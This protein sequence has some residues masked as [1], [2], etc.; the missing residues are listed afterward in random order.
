MHRL[1]G[2]IGGTSSRWAFVPPPGGLPTLHKLP[3]Y[4]PA[5]GQPALLQQALRD[6]KLGMGLGSLHATV[7]G[8]GCGTK[9]RADR[10]RATLAEVWPDASVEVESDLLG[11]ARALY[12]HDAGLVLILGTGMNAGYYNGM[13]LHLPMPSLG[14][15]LGDEGSGAD[16]GKHLLRDA[17]YGALPDALF[18]ALFPEGADLPAI[19]EAVHRSPVPQAFLASFAAP[20]A[21]VTGDVHA[22]DLVASRFDALAR[23]LARFFAPDERKSVRACG[24]VAFGFRETLKESLAQRGMR[25]TAAEADPMQGLLRYHAALK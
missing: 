19:L 14:Y 11:A 2:D 7:Y 13:D 4:N 24:S 15:V 10:M 17:L 25:L 21:A 8:A 16:I 1:I 6:A 23:L 3:G 9:A 12:G 5:T 18:K 22:H 20:L